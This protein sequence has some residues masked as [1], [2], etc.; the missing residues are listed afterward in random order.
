V[1]LLALG[2][3]FGRRDRVLRLV[4][5]AWCLC[6]LGKSWGVPVLTPL[7][8]L[9]P[10]TTQT[11]FFRYAAPGWEF[12]AVVLAALAIDDW[13]RG[14]WRPAWQLALPLLLT[15]G[16]TA[17]ALWLAWPVV[18]PAD[19]ATRLFRA[20]FIASLAGAGVMVAAVALLLARP[21]SARRGA[22]LVAVLVAGGAALFSVPRLSLPRQVAMND[23]PIGF[24]RAH[25][26][27]QRFYALGV[28]WPNY[29]AAYGLA[30]INDEYIPSPRAWA[31]H[32]LAALDPGAG[33]PLRFR[34]NFQNPGFPEQDHAA[35]LRAHLPAYEDL[36]VRFELDA[37]PVTP[38]GKCDRHALPAPVRETAAEAALA[39]DTERA[40]AGIWQRVLHVDAIGRDGDFFLLGGHSLLGTQVIIKARDAFGVELTLFHLFEGR[41]IAALAAKVEELVIAALDAMSDEEIQRLAAG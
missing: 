18:G 12:C 9:I 41:S 36:A 13:L 30:S 31:D 7:I 21:G 5:G 29:A 39:T 17:L 15:A 34:G 14:A 6:A 28:P 11:M 2:G 27:L 10:L 35:A 8:D 19:R 22:L 33:N 20:F 24:L 25:L 3:V 26:G 40:L 4:L 38:N 37:L 16:L 23:G 32:I 1:L